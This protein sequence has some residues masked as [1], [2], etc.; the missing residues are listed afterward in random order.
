M[1]H[2]QR[3]TILVIIGITGDLARRKLLPAIAQMARAK[4]LPESFLIVGIT[5]RAVTIQEILAETPA[6]SSS[7]DRQFIADHV[8][9]HQ[10]DIE[11]GDAYQSLRETLTKQ[12]NTWN[13]PAQ[14]IFYLSVPPQVS[15]PIVRHLG[16]AGFGDLP[17]TK[18]LLEKP[19]GS[20]L[21]SASM[22]I[23]STKQ[24]FSESQLYR[25]DHYLAK[26][27]AQDIVVFRRSNS[28]FKQTWNNQFI[29]KIEIIASEEIGIEGRATF[30]EQTGA[31]RDFVQSHLLQLA[32]LTLMD[33]PQAD[34]W[35]SIPDLRLAA[36]LA[37]QPPREDRFSQQ[38]VRGQYETYAQEVDNPGTLT[39][40]FVSL[41]LESTAPQW[42]GVPIILATGKALNRKTT[43]IK[44]HYKREAEEEANT[45]CLSIQ[46]REGIEVQMW[47]KKPGYARD[48]E[49]LAL[50]FT[51]NDHYQS[52]PEAYE[53]VLVDA[54]RADHSLFTSSDEVLASWQVLA[55]I[56]HHWDMHTDDLIRYASGSAP[57]T[58]H[59]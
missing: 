39:E 38:V 31:L 43:E 23:E 21:A 53:R 33:T 11:S 59:P 3:P 42:Q 26:E 2:T 27:M 7:D 46:P 4:A 41:T 40:T 37:L 6:L 12:S 16:E 30:Y 25:I 17:D 50:S 56:Q 52:L 55:S 51:Y 8:H 1:Q 14:Y 32:A 48:K 58:I 15:Q 28:L 9:M 20:D 44:I 22:L 24:Y 34:D 35:S 5:R 29:E 10:M 36:L 45:L 57:E 54:M 49:R 47:A 13:A 19:F 18:L